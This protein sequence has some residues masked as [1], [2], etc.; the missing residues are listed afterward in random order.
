VTRRTLQVWDDMGIAREMIGAGLWLEGMRSIIAG[1]PPHDELIDLSELPYGHLGLPQYETERLLA[2]HLARFGIKVERG[3][4]LSELQQN[5]NR[6]I[7]TLDNSGGREPACFD[8]VIGCD[9]AHST[10]RSLLGISFDGDAFP[11][12]FML[13]DVAIAW[14]LPRG[15]ALRA[16]RLN[17]DAAPDM[18]IAIPLPERNR[19]R[20]SMLA[21]P[22][23][24]RLATYGARDPVGARHPYSRPAASGRRR[25]GSREAAHLGSALVVGFPRQH[26]ARRNLPQRPLLHCRRRCAYSPA[27]R[28]TRHEYRNSGRLQ[29]RLE[30]GLGAVGRGKPGAAR[31]L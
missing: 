15:M 7:A 30:A 17:P 27:D 26:A 24:S 2:S 22:E 31:Q 18:F 13:G 9:G 20:V 5:D 29:P 28:R 23:L 16:L 3:T 4:A 25:A 21:P 1:H 10:V 12:D 14:D 19:Y 6:V 11:M 8:Y